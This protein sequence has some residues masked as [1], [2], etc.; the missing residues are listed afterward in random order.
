MIAESGMGASS[1]ITSDGSA[2]KPVRLRDSNLVELNRRRTIHLSR[3]IPAGGTEWCLKLES[4][5]FWC[6]NTIRK[7]QSER[8]SSNAGESCQLVPRG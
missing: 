6:Q 8:R 1:A 5:V 2:S 4:R 3:L 7:M